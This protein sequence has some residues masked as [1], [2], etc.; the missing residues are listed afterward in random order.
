M[1]DNSHPSLMKRRSFLGS[2]ALGAA[3]AG[4]ADDDR[5]GSRRSDGEAVRPRS[6]KVGRAQPRRRLATDRGAWRASRATIPTAPLRGVR[7]GHTSIMNDCEE[8][9]LMLQINTLSFKLTPAEFG[10]I[11]RQNVPPGKFTDDYKNAAGA[12][13]D[14]ESICADL[15]A[16]YAWL[17]GAYKGLSGTKPSTRW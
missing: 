1:T 12:T 8:A 16:D 4:S 17:H 10:Q 5:Q 14:L 7:L 9:L 13:V 2:L 6:G 15:D 3:A 11:I